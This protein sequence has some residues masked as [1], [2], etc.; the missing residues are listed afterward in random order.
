V[1]ETKAI[2]AIIAGCTAIYL[3]F[4]SKQFYV[5]NTG[6]RPGPPVARWKGRLWFVIGG[7]AFLLF[8][9]K[10]FFLDMHQ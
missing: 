1:N 8:G 9:L 6:T 7:A 4:T 5:A 10:Y 3:G 2:I